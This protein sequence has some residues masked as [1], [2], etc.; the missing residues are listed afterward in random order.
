MQ[1]DPKI[2]VGDRQDRA[3][4]FAGDIVH[5]AHREYVADLLRKFRQTILHH[6]PE[7]AAMH[8]LVRFRFPFLRP[9]VVVPKSDR[10]E[11]LRKFVG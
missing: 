9:F 4:L 6:L 7:L 8:D 10:N 5:F 1:H 2:A 3:N 11:L